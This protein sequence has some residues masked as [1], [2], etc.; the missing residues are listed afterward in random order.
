MC[1]ATSAASSVACL[2]PTCRP[3]FQLPSQVLL[4]QQGGRVCCIPSAVDHRT[5]VAY[6]Q[7][8]LADK[9]EAQPCWG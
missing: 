1:L 4:P 2:K 7:H 3:H 6:S 5:G 9:A 8:S